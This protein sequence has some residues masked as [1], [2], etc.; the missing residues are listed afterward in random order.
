MDEAALI[1]NKAAKLNRS[2]WSGEIEEKK[3]AFEIEEI[4][5]KS[6]YLRVEYSYSIKDTPMIEQK[7]SKIFN[8][9]LGTTYQP[10]EMFIIRKAIKGPSWFEL[11][12][13]IPAKGQKLGTQYQ[14]RVPGA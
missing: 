9:V 8:A 4:P 11:T 7:Q 1:L 2:N 13:F 12:K 6:R 10:A 14:V 5:A 3:Y